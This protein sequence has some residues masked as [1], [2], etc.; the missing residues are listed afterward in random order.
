L[1][2]GGGE[3]FFFQIW[4]GRC[5]KRFFRPS[6]SITAK[7]SSQIRDNQP[8]G[9]VVIPISSQRGSSFF[10][11]LEWEIALRFPAEKV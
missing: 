3:N 9:P 8:R 2:Y 11:H 7:R 5:S 1:A 10:N 6:K 4:V